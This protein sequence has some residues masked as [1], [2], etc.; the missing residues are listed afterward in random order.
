ML[1]A[2]GYAA[3][4]GDAG[5][6]AVLYLAW[7]AILVLHPLESV[8]GALAARQRR[9]PPREFGIVEGIEDPGILVARFPRGAIVRLGAAVSVHP[10]DQPAGT[11][12][13]VTTLGEMPIARIGL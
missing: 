5:K 7:F 10:S 11:V 13:D 6:L 4:A 2:A 3:F 9:S 1:F 12:V 8:A